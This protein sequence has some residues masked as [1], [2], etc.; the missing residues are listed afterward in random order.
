MTKKQ[1][2][3]FTDGTTALLEEVFKKHEVRKEIKQ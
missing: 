3:E 2:K 1:I